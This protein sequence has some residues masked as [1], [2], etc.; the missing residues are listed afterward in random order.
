MPDFSNNMGVIQGQLTRHA[1]NN[2]ELKRIMEGRPEKQ[3]VRARKHL[4]TVLFM[5]GKK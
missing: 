4:K 3:K 2:D 1:N 5:A